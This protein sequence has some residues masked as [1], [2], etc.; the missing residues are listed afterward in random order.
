MDDL[1]PR[2]LR[3]D[4][5]YLSAFA[6]LI[7][8]FH[9][10]M[11]NGYGFH[12]DEL[13]FLDDARHLHWGF[14][15]YPPLTSFAGRL[16]IALFGISPQVLRLPSALVNATTLVLVG[17][18]ARE[19]GAQRAAQLLTLLVV[20]PLALTFSTVLQYTTF[21]LFAWTVTILFTARVLRTSDP[22][23]WI[24]VGICI[25]LGVL[26]KYT[27]AFPLASLLAALVLLPSRHPTFYGWRGTT[28]SRYRWNTSSTRGT[29]AR[30]APTISSAIS[31]SSRSLLCLS[32]S[33]VSSGSCGVP[34]FAC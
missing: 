23:N 32:T 2:P 12:R 29:Y 14:V 6:S 26:S 22:R 16:A 31:S 1:Q 34:A 18:T 9:F 10:V 20:F 3:T 21:D 25:G 4:L 33:R 11:G 17:L 5:L 28:S 7:V 19:L 24:G 30:A 15:A 8:I 27:I 13:Q